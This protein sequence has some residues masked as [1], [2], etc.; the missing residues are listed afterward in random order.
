MLYTSQYTTGDFVKLVPN[1]VF[2]W[3]GVARRPE[4]LETFLNF[5]KVV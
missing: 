3:L 5:Y 4:N 2:I 1:C